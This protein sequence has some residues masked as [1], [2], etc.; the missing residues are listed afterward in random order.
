MSKQIQVKVVDRKGREILQQSF[1]P[2]TEVGEIKRAI[3]EKSKRSFLLPQ[4]YNS[5][6]IFRKTRDRKTIPYHSEPCRHN[7]RVINQHFKVFVLPCVIIVNQRTIR[8]F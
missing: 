1:S 6:L 7:H 2:S 8:S 3:F 5:V 4:P